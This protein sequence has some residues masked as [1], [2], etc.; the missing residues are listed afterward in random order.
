M[1][2]VRRYLVCYGLETILGSLCNANNLIMCT[3]DGEEVPFGEDSYYQEIIKDDHRDFNYEKQRDSWREGTDL[4]FVAEF[5][6]RAGE[7]SSEDEASS[8]SAGKVVDTEIVDAGKA[9]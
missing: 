9:E 1:G 6:A 4:P 8:E 5:F 2:D 7:G 3:K